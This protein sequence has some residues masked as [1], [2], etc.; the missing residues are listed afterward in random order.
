MLEA[1]K[2]FTLVLVTATLIPAVV[3]TWVVCISAWK[4]HVAGKWGERRK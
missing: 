4:E 3:L 1:F 2:V